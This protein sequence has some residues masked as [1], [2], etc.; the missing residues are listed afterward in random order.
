MESLHQRFGV[1]IQSMTD[2]SEMFSVIGGWIEDIHTAMQFQK[3][4]QTDISDA[5][6]RKVI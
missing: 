1:T 5:N 6:Y 4:N 3:T 2:V